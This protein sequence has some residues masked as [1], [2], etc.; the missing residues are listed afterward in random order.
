ML[1]KILQACQAQGLLIEK[2]K[3]RTGSTYILAN[4]RILN[5]IEL[6]GETLRRA[7]DDIAQ[8]APNWLK[9]LIQP[10]W[11]SVTVVRW[12][13]RIRKSETKQLALAQ[14]IGED[15]RD[16]LTSVYQTDTPDAVKQLPSVQVLRQVWV[17]QY[18]QVD[19]D[20]QWRRKKQQ[21]LPPAQKMIASLD[22]PEARYGS[23][24]ART[25]TG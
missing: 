9:P 22:D 18:Y 1:E 3:Q 25:W 12:T 10:D 19:N 13:H 8:V 15:G 11:A 23:K 7:L 16:L 14:T 17:Q 5:R 21:G 2:K 4:I 6:V 24:D 20:I